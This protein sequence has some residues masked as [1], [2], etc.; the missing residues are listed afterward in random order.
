MN[1]KWQW[2]LNDNR[3]HDN[4]EI[5]WRNEQSSSSSTNGTM[6]QCGCFVMDNDGY[7]IQPCKCQN[8]INLVW[9]VIQIGEFN[10]QFKFKSQI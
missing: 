10:F 3:V 1:E 9:A 2:E 8:D 5:P 4:S 7:G 6:S